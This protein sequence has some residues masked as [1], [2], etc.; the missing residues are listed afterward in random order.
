MKS[1][2]LNILFWSVISAAFIGPGTITT[3]AKSG[4][5]FGF[6]LLWALVFSTLACLI[7]QEAVARL[8]IQSGTNLGEAVSRYFKEGPVRVV[9]LLLIVGAI[10][11]GSAAYEAGNILGAVA[12]LGFIVEIKAWIAVSVIGLTAVTALT[13]PSVKRIAHFLGII[14]AVMG[15]SFFTTALR[16]GPSPAGILKGSLIPSFP[17]S[18]GSGL[19]IL[20]L[21]GTTVVPYN[22]FLGSG[23]T[24]KKQSLSEMRFGLSI[25][26][27]VGG[28]ISM[29]VLI[30]G[31]FVS[32]D[33]SYPALINTLELKLGAGAGLIFGVGVFAAGLSSA[34]TAPMASAVTAKGLFGGRNPDSWEPGALNFRLIWGLVLLTGIVFGISGLKPVPVIILA[35]ALNGLILPFITIFLVIVVNDPAIIGKKNL[36][37]IF[38]NIL[39]FAVVL[40]TLILGI[41]NLAR[42]FIGIFP[43]WEVTGR[44]LTP[45]YL[46]I[47]VLVL[48]YILKIV[49]KNR[50]KRVGEKGI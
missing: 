32:G 19:L 34:I 35:Q 33:F 25:A 31:S 28:L 18:S 22:L 43:E 29:S 1:R 14:V 13:Q 27:I 49:L 6:D 21:I 37:G 4:T 23:I 40:V 5:L 39:L 11:I 30:V 38:S 26:I 24:R 45:V 46:I 47:S 48:I 50:R 12:G 42:A 41:T 2:I 44:A 17:D 8:A 3:A 36:N 16:L 9:V 15:I 10:I 7:L 20:G